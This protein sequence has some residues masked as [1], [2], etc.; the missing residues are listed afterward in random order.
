MMLNHFK[1]MEW[2][3]N[4]I[5][6]KVCSV[7][8]FSRRLL[9]HPK[10]TRR[11]RRKNISIYSCSCFCWDFCSSWRSKF[12]NRWNK[13]CTSFNQLLIIHKADSGNLCSILCKLRQAEM[14]T[15]EWYKYMVTVRM[16]LVP[17]TRFM[18]SKKKSPIRELL[19]WKLWGGIRLLRGFSI[20][21]LRRKQ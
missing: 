18:S 14:L 2:F 3:H 15:L 13:I 5:C 9:S 6:R 8:R 10:I 21:N 12:I 4:I 19:G 17:L 7:N 1:W 16:N 11:T 20:R